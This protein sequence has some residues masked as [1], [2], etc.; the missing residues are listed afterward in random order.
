MTLNEVV[1]QRYPSFAPRPHFIKRMSMTN[2]IVSICLKRDKRK[3]NANASKKSSNQ[4]LHSQL[5]SETNHYGYHTFQDLTA[6]LRD[7]L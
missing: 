7:G 1:E 6:S 3:T 5:G 2:I 4:D